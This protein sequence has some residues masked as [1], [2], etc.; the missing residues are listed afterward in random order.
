[1][2]DLTPEGRMVVEELAQRHGFSS[3]AVTVML[4]ALAAGGGTMAQFNHPEFGG[5]G[6]WAPG[7]MV[8]IGDM[9]NNAL[10][11]RVDG[12]C[13]D[14]SARLGQPLLRPQA[15]SGQ[16]QSQEAGG[17][18]QPGVSLFVAGGGSGSGWWPADLGAPAATGSQNDVRY[19]FFPGTRRLAIEAGGKVTVYDTQDH[20]I[21]GFSQQQGGGSSLT[22]TSQH[23]LVR[24][25]DLPV[26]T[27]S[28]PP[29]AEAAQAAPVQPAPASVGATGSSDILAAIERLA[30][31]RQKG[32]LSEQEFS[33]KKAE[34][35]SRL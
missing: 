15:T 6:Q 33:A 17:G 18:G 21:G 32:I 2:N 28:S 8:M 3:D 24:V 26:V 5:M 20:Q 34:L 9:F 11:A 4:R 19:A 23:G 10:K 13:S 16:W 1:M 25:A 30:D 14:L 29:A 12:L 35:L 22:F 27:P 31:L 7:G